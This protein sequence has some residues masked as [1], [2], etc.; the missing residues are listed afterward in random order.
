MAKQSSKEFNFKKAFAEL[1]DI[2]S[3]FQNPDIDLDEALKKYERGLV[4]IKEA[5]A[6]LKETEN[7]FKVIKKSEVD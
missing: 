5:Q 4:L 2:S 6:H 1:E 7:Q 3:W